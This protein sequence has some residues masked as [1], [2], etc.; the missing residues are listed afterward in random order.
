MSRTSAP[1]H[2]FED[3]SGVTIV[4]FAM[5]L[6]ALCLLLLGTL[7]LGYRMY[8]ASIVQ[9]ALHEAAR[10]ATVGNQTNEQIDARIR[11]RLREFSRQATIETS[12]RSYTDFTDVRVAE[13]IRTDSDPVGVYN[14]GDCYLDY[15]NNGRY[16]LDRGRAGFGQA[17]DVVH[18]QISMSYPRLF[19]LHSLVGW[20]STETVIS[21]TVLRNQPYAG[22]TVFNPPEICT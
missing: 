2:L 22:R 18:Y 1:R 14:T 4:E 6:P 21:N 15:N 16:D 5:I 19:P 17:D 12:F 7:E 10:L 11:L 20:S 13:T 8:V 9:G 3:R